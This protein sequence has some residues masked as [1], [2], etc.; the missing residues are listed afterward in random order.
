MS[1][2]ERARR[3][4][5]AMMQK[6][7]VNIL[8]LESSCDETAAAVIQNGRT[9]LSNVIDS[10][11][12]LHQP[13]G[14]VV[15]EIASR[16]HVLS[17]ERVI[18]AALQEAGL[19]FDE[20]DA[21]SVAYGPGLVG[22]LLVSVSAAKAIAFAHDLPLIGVHHIEGHISANYLAHPDLSAPFVCLVASGGHS[23]LVKVTK[24]GILTLGATRDDAVGEAFD[25]V[26]RALGLGY[27][28][29]PLIDKIAKEG[30]PDA[31]HFPRVMMEEDNDDFSFSGLKTAVIN[32]LHNLSQKGEQPDV[33]DLAASFQKAAVEV[34]VAKTIRAAKREGIGTVALAGGVASNSLLR[35][36]LQHAALANGLRAVYPPPVLCTDN[37]AMGGCAAYPH[38]M[39]GELMDMTLNAV[40]DLQ[41]DERL[42]NG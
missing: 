16:Q 29:G 19:D 6:E 22:A 7:H 12:A 4:L 24:G 2:M 18:A 21:V 14:G 35:E 30:N 33:A 36:T 34:L 11:I 8:A 41:L 26:A 25:K 15:P 31:F 38:L 28:G 32:F 39:R 3:K 37:A 42:G 9:I 20:L 1:Y 40:P 10:Q 27:P 17:M 23:H 13:Y 5:P